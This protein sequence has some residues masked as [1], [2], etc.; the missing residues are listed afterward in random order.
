L[1]WNTFPLPPTS[2]ELRMKIIDAGAEVIAAR[3]LQPGIPLADLYAPG[4]MSGPLVEAHN[5]LDRVVD[6]HFDLSGAAP[7]ELARQD[8][9]FARYE[10]LVAPL[11]RDSTQ[12]RRPR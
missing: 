12:Q 9:L 5:S 10:E 3:N 6:G 2:N 7:T 8:T 11:A 4:A 1:T